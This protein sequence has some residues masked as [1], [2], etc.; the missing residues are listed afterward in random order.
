MGALD[1]SAEHLVSGDD[2]RVQRDPEAGA[3]WHAGPARARHIGGDGERLE[4]QL[5]AEAVVGR[6]LLQHWF[7]GKQPTAQ[8]RH[9]RKELEV[10]RET[11]R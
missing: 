6:V 10:H 8:W 3:V 5:I 2:L 7:V 4:R 1:V 11:H 9:G